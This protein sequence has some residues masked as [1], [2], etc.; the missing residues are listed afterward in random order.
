MCVSGNKHRIKHTTG[1]RD[2]EYMFEEAVNF[3]Y[4]GTRWLE[5]TKRIHF[6][7]EC[8]KENDNHTRIYLWNY[9]NKDISK[10]NIKNMFNITT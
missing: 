3:K 10:F 1:L 4:S 2:G 8:N 5:G 7:K 6:R 9:L